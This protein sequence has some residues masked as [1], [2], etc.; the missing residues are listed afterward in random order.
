MQQ[1]GM[2]RPASAKMVEEEFTGELLKNKTDG[3][4]HR[5][6]VVKESD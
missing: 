1:S 6:S 3:S 5:G 4:S 2:W